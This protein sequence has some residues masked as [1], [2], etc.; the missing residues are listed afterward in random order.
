MSC[1]VIL[2]TTL[3]SIEDKVCGRL[4]VC[5]ELYDFKVQWRLVALADLC[6]QYPVDFWFIFNVAKYL[7]CF[8][9]LMFSN[10]S[11]STLF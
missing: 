10:T 6:C 9:K 2:A 7:A 8:E 3:Q 4:L 5:F 11:E 1:W